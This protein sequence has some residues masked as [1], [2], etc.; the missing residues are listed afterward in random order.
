MILSLKEIQ[1]TYGITGRGVIHVGAHYGEEYEDYKSFGIEE[2]LFFEPAINSFNVLKDKV[3]Q[4]E[5][6]RLL[7][8]AL[9]NEAG[10]I[11]MYTETRNEG[12]SS[13]ILKPV[14]CSVM[15][16]WITFDS[17]ETVKID[18]LDNIEFD[19]TLFNVLN[20]DVQGY[21]MEV[22]KGASE[23]LKTIDIIY[24]ELN[25]VEMYEGCAL[26]S[27][28]DQ[29]LGLHNFKRVADNIEVNERWGDGLYL[30]I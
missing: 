24:T 9:G 28:M 12:C 11:K 26:V 22:F 5:R 1:D 13:S 21:E 3:P 29:F 17:F 7:N 27:E 8:I 25:A 2:M 6:I 4:S 10:E 20:V 15:Y 18:K 19:R 30:K 16:P 14:H 23:T